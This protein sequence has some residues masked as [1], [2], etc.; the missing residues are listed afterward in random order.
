[1][2]NSISLTN[3]INIFWCYNMV[4]FMVTMCVSYTLCF[5]FSLDGVIYQIFK[6]NKDIVLVRPWSW[7]FM[8]NATYFRA[9][10]LDVTDIPTNVEDLNCTTSITGYSKNETWINSIFFLSIQVPYQWLA[11]PVTE[12]LHSST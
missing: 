1:M 9:F 8:L 11:A 4:V 3:F 5:I 10:Q 7:M 6:K 2:L 12:A